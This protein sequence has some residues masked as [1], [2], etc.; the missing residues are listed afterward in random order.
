MRWRNCNYLV[1]AAGVVSNIS[2]YHNKES[3]P[4]IQDHLPYQIACLSFSSVI[5]NN[6]K[7][8][9]VNIIKDN[10]YIAVEYRIKKLS[11]GFLT[12]Y[13]GPGKGLF[14][15]YMS[16]IFPISVWQI[17]DESTNVLI[18]DNNRNGRVSMFGWRNI[19]NSFFRVIKSKALPLYAI[20]T[21]E[22]EGFH[23]ISPDFLSKEIG[24]SL[25]KDESVVVLGGAAM[26]DLPVQHP[27]LTFMA[28][29]AWIGAKYVKN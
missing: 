20:K 26:R 8:P 11:K 2:F 17:W 3:I 19:I 15:F 28:H 9:V 12:N 6:T 4:D 16:Q 22:G 10:Q 25:Y 18:S 23:Y 5:N 24:S 21:K 14:V 7:T 1:L 13:Y 27:S 29:A